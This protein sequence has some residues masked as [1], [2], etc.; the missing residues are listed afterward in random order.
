LAGGWVAGEEGVTI[1]ATTERFDVI[2]FFAFALDLWEL[3][4]ELARARFEHR[5][6]RLNRYGYGVFP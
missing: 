4:E 6:V 5:F 3:A 2:G 1:F